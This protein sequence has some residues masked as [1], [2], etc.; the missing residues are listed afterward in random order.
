MIV[1]QEYRRLKNGRKLYR[2]Y[3][4]RK[5]K[6]MQHPTEIVYDDA[7][8]VEGVP[9]TYTETDIPIEEHKEDME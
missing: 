7:V 8:D 4:D 5:V 2:T 9:Y 3:S 6:I 1:R